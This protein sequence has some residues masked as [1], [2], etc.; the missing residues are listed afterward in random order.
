[1]LVSMLEKQGWQDQGA[2]EIIDM[3]DT[4]IMRFKRTVADLADI[5]KVEKQVD[6]VNDAVDVAEVISDILLDLR[7]PIEQSGAIIEVE[8]EKCVGVIFSEKNLKSIFYN[9]ISNAIKYRHPERN[10]LIRVSCQ[11]EDGFF[12]VSVQDNGLGLNDKDE[13]KVFGMFQRQHS[14]VEGSGVGLYIVKKMIDNTG[15]KITVKST[16]GEGTVFRVYFKL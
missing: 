14:H 5:A 6:D 4:S 10:P 12:V 7:M 9:L 1:V 2:K 11:H 16:I 13:N 3:I 8:L 15:G